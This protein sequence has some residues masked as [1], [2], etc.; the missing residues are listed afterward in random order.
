MQNIKDN[1]QKNS[2]TEKNT[3]QNPKTGMEVFKYAF[4]KMI[5]TKMQDHM[6]KLTK[7]KTKLPNNDN[8]DIMTK[9][10]SARDEEDSQIASERIETQKVRNDT[11]RNLRDSDYE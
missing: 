11:T 8:K 5:K 9:Q 3:G 4:G 10:P 7:V 1:T 2:I 6:Q